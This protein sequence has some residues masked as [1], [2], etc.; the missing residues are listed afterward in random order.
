MVATDSLVQAP[1]VR[2]KNAVADS[3]ADNTLA[4]SA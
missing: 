4:T 1:G 3:A 2:R